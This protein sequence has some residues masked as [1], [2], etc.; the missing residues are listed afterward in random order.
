[1]GWGAFGGDGALFVKEER[2]LR[3][4]DKGMT[5]QSSILAYLVPTKEEARKAQHFD[6]E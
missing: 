6:L 3:L 1:M 5:P 4:G 2:A